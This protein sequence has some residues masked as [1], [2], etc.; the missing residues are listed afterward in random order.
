MGLKRVYCLMTQLLFI[1]NNSNLR[2]V[3]ILFFILSKNFIPV[4]FSPGLISASGV[5]EVACLLLLKSALRILIYI[6]T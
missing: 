5:T 6:E 4:I 1:S 2:R 3:E